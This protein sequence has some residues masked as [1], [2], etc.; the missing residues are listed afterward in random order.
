MEKRTKWTVRIAAIAVSLIALFVLAGCREAGTST[1]ANINVID[2]TYK[3]SA[4]DLATTG[5]DADVAQNVANDMMI[6]TLELRC[7]DPNSSTTSAGTGFIVSEDGYVVTNAHVVTYETY[8]YTY[9]RWGRPVISGV[10]ENPYSSV[11]ANFYSDRTAQF[12]ME[13]VAYDADLDLAV[14]KFKNLPEGG[15]ER[16]VTFADSSELKYGQIVVAIGNANGYG[17]AVTSG[18]V[19]MPQQQ[20]RTEEGGTVRDVIQTDAAINPGNSGGPLFDK[21]AHV[22]GVNSL[23]IVEENTE[24]MGYAI[25]SNTAME[26]LDSVASEKGITISYQTV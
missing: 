24:N 13:V 2:G 7:S 3:V 9:D 16:I 5:S 12:E 18:V 10:T 14:L 1:S 17:L 6:A 21:Y 25:P 22:I 26:Y 11:L 23:K 4:G 8:N 15:F 20:I 19:S